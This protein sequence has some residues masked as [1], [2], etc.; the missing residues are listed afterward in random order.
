LISGSGVILPG[1]GEASKEVWKS[2]GSANTMEV[3]IAKLT[4]IRLENMRLVS[5]GR[6]SSP[7][8]EAQSHI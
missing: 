3:D 2:L 4:K 5:S 7:K 6:F 8:A 1:I